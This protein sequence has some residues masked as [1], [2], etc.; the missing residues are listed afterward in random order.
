MREPKSILVVGRQPAIGFA[1]LEA[2]LGADHVQPFGKET[3]LSDIEVK[4]IPFERLGGTMRLAKILTPIEAKTWADIEKHLLKTVAEHASY[5]P[6]KL[7]FGLSIFGFQAKVDQVSKTAMAIKK[8]IKATEKSVRMVPHKGL[9]LSSATVFHNRLTG[10]SGWELLIASDGKHTYLCQTT[11][12]QDFEGYAARDQA[13]PKRDPRVGMLPPKLAQIIVNLA[14][15]AGY[16]YT[17]PQVLLDPFCGTGVVLQEAIIMG[18]RGFGSDLDARMIDFAHQNLEWLVKN[19]DSFAKRTGLQEGHFYKLE[20]GDA[21]NHTWLPAPDS[22][23]SETYLGPPLHALPESQ[24]MRQIVHDISRLH[25]KFL[26]NIGKQIEPG[27]RL[28]LAVPAWKVGVPAKPVLRGENTKTGFI[29]LSTLEK[30]KDLGYTRID[31]EY[32]S[33]DQ[34]IYHREGQLVA[35]ELIVLVKN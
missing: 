25:N 35:R 10:P 15:G 16:P 20:V 18:F 23:A 11:N 1:E 33:A 30:L 22:V 8:A 12:I 9:E 29:H 6:G 14:V 34:L 13:R 31:F 7:S 26:E 27:T 19:L 3:M 32:A 5:V 28:C 17:H 21:T 24:K 2:V 4:D